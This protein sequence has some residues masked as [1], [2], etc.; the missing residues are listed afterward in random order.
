MGAVICFVFC[1]YCDLLCDHQHQWITTSDMHNK[2]AVRTRTLCSL[3]SFSLFTLKMG[4]C[5]ISFACPL[6]GSLSLTRLSVLATHWLTLAAAHK[7]H[8]VH[9]RRTR[10]TAFELLNVFFFTQYIG[11]DNKRRFF[12]F[13]FFF[14]VAGWPPGI[15]SI[16]PHWICRLNKS[17]FC[18][19]NLL[20]IHMAIECIIHV[21]IADQMIICNVSKA[22]AQTFIFAFICMPNLSFSSFLT[23]YLISCTEFLL[24]IMILNSLLS[25]SLRAILL[26]QRIVMPLNGI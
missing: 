20:V 3:F 18:Y 2:N 9:L 4:F 26:F 16:H 15:V 14:L 10:L 11:Q 1:F 12:L 24:I 5:F 13:F 21:L 25:S 23:V 8:E 7:P 17:R 22:S 6:P 19:I